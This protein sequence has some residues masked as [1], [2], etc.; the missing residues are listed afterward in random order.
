MYIVCAVA[1]LKAYL[2]KNSHQIDNFF[3]SNVDP[4]V[5]A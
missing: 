1:E 5:V 3:L 4:A 2:S